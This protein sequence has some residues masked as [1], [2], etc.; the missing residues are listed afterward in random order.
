MIIALTALFSCGLIIGLL[1]FRWPFLG[2]LSALIALAYIVRL[3]LTKNMSL[4]TLSEVFVLLTAL[5]SGYLACL[6]TEMAVS[7]LQSARAQFARRL[8]LF[9]VALTLATGAFVLTMLKDPPQS[10]ASDPAGKLS[11][12]ADMHVP[13]GLPTP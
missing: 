9:A 12:K 8:R 10:V 3:G 1:R 4:L 6:A 13:A 7:D 11:P 2:L 5:Q